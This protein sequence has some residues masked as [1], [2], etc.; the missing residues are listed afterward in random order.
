M[1]R[2]NLVDRWLQLEQFQ[3][4]LLNM[5][6]LYPFYEF[7]Q[8]YEGPRQRPGVWAFDETDYMNLLWRRELGKMARLI[9]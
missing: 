9:K 1:E 3:M 4:K 7:V 5:A 2:D 8:R 6:R